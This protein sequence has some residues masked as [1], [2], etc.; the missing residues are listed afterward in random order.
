[1]LRA[2]GTTRTQVNAIVIV[3]GLLFGLI[4]VAVGIVVGTGIDVIHIVVSSGS[5]LL[6]LIIACPFNWRNHSG[7]NTMDNKSQR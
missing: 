3:E 1:M 6:L 7:W 5:A 2:A 4:G